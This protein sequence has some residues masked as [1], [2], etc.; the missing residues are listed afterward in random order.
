MQL[1]KQM[2]ILK[3]NVRKL[4]KVNE[5]KTKDATVAMVCLMCIVDNYKINIP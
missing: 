2:D 3:E 4:T 5:K 1:N